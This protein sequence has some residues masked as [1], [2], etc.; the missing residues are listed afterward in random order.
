M[1]EGLAGA[2]VQPAPER[3]RG[4]RGR[5]AVRE[6]RVS[7]LRTHFFPLC[8]QKCVRT[9]V[10]LG[11]AALDPPQSEAR[12][13]FQSLCDGKDDRARRPQASESPQPAATPRPVGAAGVRAVSAA[14]AATAAPAARRRRSPSPSPAPSSEFELRSHRLKSPKRPDSPPMGALLRIGLQTRPVFT[15]APPA[16]L[17]CRAAGRPPSPPDSGRR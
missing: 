5:A 4:G 6:S 16:P 13:T 1:G 11:H 12:S 8:G 9:V 14:R 15:P 10:R 3:L 17:R 2:E 7:Y